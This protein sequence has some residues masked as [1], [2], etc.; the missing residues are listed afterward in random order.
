MSM[1][2]H[3]KINPKSRGRWCAGCGQEHGS[4]YDCDKYDAD[5]LAEIAALNERYLANLRDPAWCEKQ[6]ANGVPPEG[7]AIFRVLAGL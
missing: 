1:N 3:G 7:I 5:T 6:V 4:L 2:E